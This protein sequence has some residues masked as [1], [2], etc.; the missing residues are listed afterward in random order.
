MKCKRAR[1]MLLDY[2]NGTLELEDNHLVQEH[3]AGCDVCH[4][5][6]DMLSKILNIVDDA[7]VEY[8]PASVWGNFL[9]D[10]HKRIE[11]EAALLFRRQYKQRLYFLPGWAAFFTIVILTIFT[12][13]MPKYYR[14]AI[15]FQYQTVEDVENIEPVETS[16]PPAVED[17]S[18]PVIV[19][20]MISKMLITE[21][22]AAELDKLRK[23]IQSEVLIPPHYDGYDILVNTSEESKSTE[24]E[25]GVIQF[26]LEGEF[27]EY[28]D[29]PIIE[30]DV[31]DLGAM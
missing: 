1:K 19:A 31:A 10:L 18:E 22:E 6:L 2:V 25:E 5:E 29:N 24:D 15:P 28:G 11:R 4:R 26:L 16:S 9:P 14:P 27:A 23:F 8:P 17:S 20:G 7:K 12:I 13:V 21:A 3:T 30:P